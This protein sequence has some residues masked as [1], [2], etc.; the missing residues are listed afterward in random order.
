[1]RDFLFY[2]IIIIDPKHA[3]NLAKQFYSDQNIDWWKTPAESPDIN[4][5]ELIWA[6][7]KQ[8]LR[9]K[10]KPESQADLLH[11]CRLFWRNELDTA[12]CNKYIDHL[13][14]VFPKIIELKGHPSGY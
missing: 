4:P 3:A 13:Y 1:M 12:K 6:E 2:I 5:I 7:M 9:K 8:F 10:V 14:K 11:G